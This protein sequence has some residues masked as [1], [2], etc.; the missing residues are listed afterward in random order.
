M[1]GRHRRIA[2]L[3]R[4]L[5]GLAWASA[6]LLAPGVSLP[7]HAQDIRNRAL[8][9]E[10][11]RLQH[12]F[13]ISVFAD[14]VPGARSLAVGRD[15]TV[16]VGTRGH[17]RVYA[18][19]HAD[20]RANRVTVLASGLNSPNGVALRDGAL[21]VAEISRILRFDAIEARLAEG[22]VP[23]PA[24]VTDRFP[25]DGHHGWKFIAFGPDGRLYVPVGAP[26]NICAPDPDRYAL[27]SRIDV[28]RAKEP[29][30]YEVVA[31]G[32]RNSVGFDWQ[33]QTGDLWFT[34]NG[35]DW[36]G[37]DQPSDELNHVQAAGQHFGFPY[38]HQGDLPDPEF[39]SRSCSEF[40]PPAA[41]LG[42]HVAALGMRFYTGNQF[43]AEFRNNIFIAEH[44]SW[45]RSTKIGYRVKR[46]VLEGNRVVRQ[47][48]FAE[49]WLEGDRVWG[50]PVDVAQLADGSLLVSDD[51]AGAIYRIT[52]QG[53]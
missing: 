27:I 20:G 13:A 14:N 49:G 12:G 2:A 42:P 10:R 7:T 15:N 37:D 48:T 40:A 17:G 23:P 39:R 46:V 32:V 26:C 41:K 36:L 25:G 24:V 19:R 44:G 30:S 8:P 6:L 50:R 4:S 52:W 29:A 1:A 34:D 9:I 35:R 33:P 45:N 22:R 43:P 16:F 31:R 21:Y 18:V 53:R 3:R 47:E 28:G 5:V 51:H 38:C 11:I